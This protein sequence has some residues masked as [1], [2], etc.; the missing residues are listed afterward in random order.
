MY[1]PSTLC[2]QAYNST[3]TV[4]SPVRVIQDDGVR[5]LQVDAETSSARGQHEDEFV[6]TLPVEVG[7]AVLSVLIVIVCIRMCVVKQAKKN[8]WRIIESSAN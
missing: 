4:N 5:S 1:R 6:R 3:V 7:D 2:T 8:Q